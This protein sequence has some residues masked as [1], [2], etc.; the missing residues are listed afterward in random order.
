MSIQ[1]ALGAKVRGLREKSGLT[2][3]E[4][5]EI[6][7]VESPSYISK[8]ERGATSPSY[9][10]LARIAKALHVDLKDLF[11]VDY[12]SVGKAIDPM[13]KWMLRFRA[14]LKGHKHSSIKTAYDILRKVL[15]THKK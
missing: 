3:Q 1:S 9:E 4:L 13:D 7:G 5:A 12:K 15:G 2:Q 8:I 14:L 6:V 11:D 10:L